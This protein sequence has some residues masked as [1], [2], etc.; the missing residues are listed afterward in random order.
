MLINRITALKFLTLPLILAETSK[1]NTGDQPQAFTFGYPSSPLLN[2][3][4]LPV[5]PSCPTP[6][7]ISAL[8]TTNN[9]LVSD[10]V[11]P[12]TLVVLVHEQLTDDAGVHYGRIYARSMGIGNM[13]TARSLR[14]PWANGT[15][16][17]GC[18]W[19][20]NGISGGC[21][22]SPHFGIALHIWYF[23]IPSGS[24]DHYEL[25]LDFSSLRKFLV[26]M[27]NTIS[28]RIVGHIATLNTGCR[29]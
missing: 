24:H 27:S 26:G 11:A 2:S 8:T 3:V 10:P 20:S 6:L 28:T 12:Y 4:V 15:Q 7:I 18:I 21:Q 25:R 19:S 9:K 16:F 17:I 1:N 5:T 22:V 14:H 13:D 29:H 23:L